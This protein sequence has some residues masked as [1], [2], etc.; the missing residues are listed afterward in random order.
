MTNISYP[1]KLSIFEKSEMLL[2]VIFGE[3]EEKLLE[4]PFSVFNSVWNN[5]G[6]IYLPITQSLEALGNSNLPFSWE[7]DVRETKVV[8]YY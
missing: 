3:N 5:C 7:Y 4:E 8:I 1:H 2:N 6:K